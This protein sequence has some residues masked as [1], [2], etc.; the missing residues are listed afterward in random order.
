MHT[1]MTQIFTDPR[2]HSS[3]TS[4]ADKMSSGSGGKRDRWLFPLSVRV[5]H[6]ESRRESYSGS[7]SESKIWAHQRVFRDVNWANE[8]RKNKLKSCVQ[9]AQF[10]SETKCQPLCFKGQES[11]KACAHIAPI[12]KTT[13]VKS[14]RFDVFKNSKSQPR[15]CTKIVTEFRNSPRS[16]TSRCESEEVLCT[17][18]E[19]QERDLW[20]GKAR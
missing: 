17:A 9:P 10:G 7:F 11:W 5:S 2:Q 15:A 14:V 19:T 6:H 4:W 8:S 3:S 20:P 18:R 16:D 12:C 13:S 1:P